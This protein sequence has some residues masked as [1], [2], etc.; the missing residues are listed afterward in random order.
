MLLLLLVSKEGST[1]GQGNEERREQGNRSKLETS[2][3]SGNRKG[4]NK[5]GIMP[6][7]WNRHGPWAEGRWGKAAAALDAA[8]APRGAIPRSRG[9]AILL[10]LFSLSRSPA[11]LP[12]GGQFHGVVRLKSGREMTP[13]GRRGPPSDDDDDTTL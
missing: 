10:Y 3:E 6:L 2:R 1:E 4:E 13:T 12:S 9:K 8:G 7:R 5:D 11:E